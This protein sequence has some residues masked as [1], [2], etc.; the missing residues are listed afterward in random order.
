MRSAAACN[1]ASTSPEKEKRHQQAAAESPEQNFG[2]VNLVEVTAVAT[3][4]GRQDLREAKSTSAGAPP[5]ITPAVES[6]SPAKKKKKKK[7]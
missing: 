4:R 5:R 6:A 2:G 7:N 1:N 3:R